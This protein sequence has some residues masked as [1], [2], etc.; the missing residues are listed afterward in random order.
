MVKYRSS[1]DLCF[2]V[3]RK[4]DM[5]L[6]SSTNCPYS[7]RRTELMRRLKRYQ[8]AN[9]KVLIIKYQR[10]TR[11]DKSNIATHDQQTMAAVSCVE[12]SSLLPTTQEYTVIGIDEGQF[13]PDT[14]KFA[15]EMANQGKTVIVAALDGCYRRTGF[16]DIL[17]LVPL[18]ESVIKLTAVCMICFTEA[19]YTKRIGLEKELEIIGGAD[20]YMAVCRKCYFE[21]TVSGDGLKQDKERTSDSKENRVLS[22]VTSN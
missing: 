21:D 14:V 16:G 7:T 12:L 1:L 4:C 2:R 17:Q 8:F 6:G 15:E 11:Y 9:Y 19:S 20:K 22:E 10:D 13:F 18:A 3:K 5:S